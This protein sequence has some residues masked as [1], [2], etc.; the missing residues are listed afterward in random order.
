MPIQWNKKKKS[1][2]IDAAYKLYKLTLTLRKRVPGQTGQLPTE[3]IPILLFSQDDTMKCKQMVYIHLLGDTLQVKDTVTMG[4]GILLGQ[5][6]LL[7]GCLPEGGS[8]LQLP[9]G[10]GSPQ[11]QRVEKFKFQPFGIQT[12]AW[13]RGET[14]ISKFVPLGC[15]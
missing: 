13:R 7:P 9:E 11:R 4:L 15:L 12:T 5:G 1:V 10:I 2:F 8:K 14:S 6:Q 3:S